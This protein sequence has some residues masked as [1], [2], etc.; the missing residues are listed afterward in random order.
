MYDIK[1]KILEQTYIQTSVHY[2]QYTHT[3][4]THSSGR[5]LVHIGQHLALGRARVA[6]EEDVDVAALWYIWCR[7][8]RV[9][10]IP[11]MYGV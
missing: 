3:V 8:G 7:G 4:Y 1:V 10:D 6:A 2:I 9:Y 5:D 11:Y